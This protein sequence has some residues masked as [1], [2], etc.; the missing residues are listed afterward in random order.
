MSVSHRGKDSIYIAAQLVAALQGIVSRELNP[1][2][3]G[4]VTVGSF[5]GGLRTT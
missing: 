1:L 3:P 2:E 5:R 4:I